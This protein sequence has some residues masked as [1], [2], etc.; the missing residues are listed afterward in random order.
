M[1]LINTPPIIKK[2][3]WNSAVE[4]SKKTRQALQQLAHLRLGYDSSPAFEN[5]TLNN[6]TASRLVQTDANKQLT[7]VSDLTGWVSGTADE[8]DVADDGDG[9]ITIGIVNPLIVGK[10]G[11]GAATL[12][13]HSLLVGSGTDPIT[14]LGAATNGQLPIG[15]T[16]ADPVLATLTGTENQLTVTN[17]AGSI[18]LS[19]PQ[20]IHTGA[21]PTFDGATFTDVVTGIF[22]TAG[23]HFATKEYVDLAARVVRDFF[24]S[25]TASDVGAYNYAYYQ[26]TGEAESTVV[27]A[28][29]GEGDDQLLKGFITEAGEPGTPII[30]KGIIS[31]HIHAKKGASNQRT[32]T[33]YATLV[34]YETDTTETVLATTGNSTELTDSEAHLYLHAPITEDVHIDETDRLICKIYANVG[35]GAQDAVVTLYLEGDTDSFFSSTVT[36]HVWQNHGDVLDDLNALGANTADGEFLVGTGAGALAWESGATARTSIG[37]GTADDV[38]FN[39]I[40][41]VNLTVSSGEVTCG[42]INKASGDLSLEIGGTSSLD[43]GATRNRSNVN[44]YVVSGSII[45]GVDDTTKGVMTAYGSSS[46]VYGGALNLYTGADYDDTIDSYYVRA[47]EDDLQIGGTAGTAITIAGTTVTYEGDVVITGTATYSS[48]II[49]PDDGWVGSATT[50]QAIQV[51]ASGNITIPQRLDV[52]GDI[53]VTGN[54]LL[55]AD[56]GGVGYSDNSPMLVFNDTDD[57]VEVTGKLTVSSTANIT[58]ALTAANYTASNLLTACAT[59]AG[60]LDFSSNVTLTVAETE[61][62]TNYHTDARAA[63]WLAANH[64][65]TYTHTDIALNTTH[66]TSDGSDHTYIDQAVTTAASPTFTGLTLSGLTEGSILF[67][68]AGGSVSENNSELFWDATANDGHG[69]LGLG[70]DNPVTLFYI[71]NSHSK[72]GYARLGQQDSTSTTNYW[73]FGVGDFADDDSNDF[74]LHTDG[75]A[76]DAFVIK[77]DSGN[78]GINVTAPDTRLEVFHNG[79]QLKLSFD[80]TDNCVF[81][82]DTA[83]VLTITPSGAAVD[84]ASKNLTG[85]AAISCS[86]L[87][88]THT[89]PNLYIKDSDH[90][91]GAAGYVARLVFLD[92][93]G[94]WNSYIEADDAYFAVLP[95]DSRN[96]WLGKGNTKVSVGTNVWKNSRLTVHG[97]IELSE[98]A[99]A[100]ASG[101]GYGQIWVK[102]TTPCELW[103]TDDAGTDHQIAFV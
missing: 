18:T 5:I 82:V 94:G 7:S 35:S 102:N 50:N 58:G 36:S 96:I 11:T 70:T 95:E 16:G 63:T 72:W 13:D 74:Y 37:L 54:I 77:R 92:S 84:F 59:S 89:S 34:R 29:L 30:P 91:K 19:L 51:A 41:G 79:N 32:T 66:R 85:I 15:S 57:Q 101:N 93:A 53:Q 28:A 48:N 33:L 21:S 80:A 78:I 47:Y 90:L 86:G 76:G 64:E 22:P 45:A 2:D 1:S 42:S 46:G 100:V 26:E 3:N 99:A 38:Q 98:M 17:G 9:T 73:D 83:G 65:T 25:D 52:T 31:V 67:A 69:G 49:I 24:M 14:S 75:A 12:T 88:L 8:I 68:G 4:F 97:G 55:M 27:S 61:T 6:L 10:G 87:T 71:M 43:I 44:L 103:F 62:T 56:N 40:T 20:D 81:G 39:N 23:A 60:S